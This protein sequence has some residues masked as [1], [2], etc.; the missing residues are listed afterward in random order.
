MSGIKT[1]S[2]DHYGLVMGMIRELGIM[3]VIEEELPTRSA[4]KIVTHAMGV[5]AMIINGLGY[6]NK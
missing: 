6:A 5:A 3:E 2:L 1:E 4:S